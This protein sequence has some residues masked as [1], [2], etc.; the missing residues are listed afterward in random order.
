MRVHLCSFVVL[1]VFSS[2]AFAQTPPKHALGFNLGDDYHV[3]NY[4][5]L[6]AWRQKLATVSGRLK[7]E[8]IGLTAEA[9]ICTWR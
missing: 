9:A 8:D 1:L 6:E 3:T 2:S 7:I 5:Q 4:T